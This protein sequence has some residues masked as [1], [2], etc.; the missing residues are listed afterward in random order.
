MRVRRCELSLAGQRVGE[1]KEVH[2]WL[3]QI[4]LIYI[5]STCRFGGF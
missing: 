4:K 2:E 5:T 1:L 3:G